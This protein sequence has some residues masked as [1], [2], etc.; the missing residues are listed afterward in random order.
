MDP[1]DN[2]E[3]PGGA[4]QPDTQAEQSQAG[5]TPTIQPPLVLIGAPYLVGPAVVIGTNHGPLNLA[6]AELDAIS[7]LA[8]QARTA[9]NDA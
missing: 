1:N 9:R 2:P 4:P 8:A 6:G 3:P 7:D 5:A